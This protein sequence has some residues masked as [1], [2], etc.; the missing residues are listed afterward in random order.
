MILFEKLWILISDMNVI[1]MYHIYKYITDGQNPLFQLE[2][3][4]KDGE[5]FSTQIYSVS[6]I[7]WK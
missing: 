7:H 6:N 3:E 5:I 4:N 2:F 1:T